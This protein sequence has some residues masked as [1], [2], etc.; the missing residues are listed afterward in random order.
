MAAEEE[1][2]ADAL[3]EDGCLGEDS[4]H[5]WKRALVTDLRADRGMT[6]LSR[7]S[8]EALMISSLSSSS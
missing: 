5:W 6:L 4:S 7:L 1:E 8:S 2:G 3:G